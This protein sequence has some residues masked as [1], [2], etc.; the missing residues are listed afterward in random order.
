MTDI[1][2]ETADWHKNNAAIRRI[3]ESVF[4][5]EQGVSPEQEWDSDDSTATH[6]LA[7]DGEHAIGTA[8]LLTSGSIGRLSVLKDW[9]G[10]NIGEA[11]MQAAITEAE[12]QGLT[13]QTLAA[14]THAAGFYERLGFRVISDEFIEAGIPHIEM[15]RSAAD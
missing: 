8:R 10:M 9:R 11:L 3:R 6:F 14:Q 12:R 5:K 2:V 13:E 4:V 7:Y 15:L 1:R